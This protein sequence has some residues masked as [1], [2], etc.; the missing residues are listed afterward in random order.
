V[1]GVAVDPPGNIYVDGQ[2]DPNHGHAFVR[3]SNPGETLIW[4]RDLHIG[5]DETVVVDVAVDPSG[6]VYVAGHVAANVFVRKYDR[7]GREL[8]TSR[9]G[10]PDNDIASALIV[11]PTGTCSGQRSTGLCDAFLAQLR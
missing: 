5:N 7:D 2:T 11:H 4:E 3:K 10:T 8:W 1:R 6:D 9:L